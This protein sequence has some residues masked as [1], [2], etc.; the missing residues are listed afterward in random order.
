MNATTSTSMTNVKN[1]E[2]VVTKIGVRC[3]YHPEVVKQFRALNGKWNQ[4]KKAWYFDARDKARV[5]D[6]LRKVF[7][8]APGDPAPRLV[9]VVLKPK[10]LDAMYGVEAISELGRVVAVRRGRDARVELGDGVRILT[11]GFRPSGGSA[12][13]PELAPEDGTSLEVRDVPQLLAEQLKAQY[14]DAVEIVG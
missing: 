1:A 14:G 11:G 10:F 2:G 4:D 13:K 5:V 8:V 7:G 9:T 3:P 6:V 12:R